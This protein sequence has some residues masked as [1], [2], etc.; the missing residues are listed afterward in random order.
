M[1]P[2]GLALL[3]EG[4]LRPGALGLP[5]GPTPQAVMGAEERDQD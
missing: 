1:A 2:G 4:K 3:H 5:L